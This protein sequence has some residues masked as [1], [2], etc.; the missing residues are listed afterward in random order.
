MTELSFPV[1]CKKKKRG[2]WWQGR[3]VPIVQIFVYFAKKCVVI[4]V[5]QV[6]TVIFFL[7]K[8]SSL[9]KLQRRRLPALEQ[10]KLSG[11]KTRHIF[12]FTRHDLKKTFLSAATITKIEN[13][14]ETI[15][16]VWLSQTNFVSLVRTGPNEDQFAFQLTEVYNGI[17]NNR[18]S[19]NRVRHCQRK[20][21]DFQPC[22]VYLD[23]CTQ[24][25]SQHHHVTCAVEKIPAAP[26]N[27]QEFHYTNAKY[28]TVWPR[29]GGSLNSI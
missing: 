27:S 2:P 20:P 19:A 25:P 29:S 24:H 14:A 18:T 16:V 17:D 28:G 10:D 4:S 9:T 11:V 21:L 26:K 15:F 6:R 13:L 7:T 5:I 1:Q 3:P 8:L 12:Q 22:Y 23:N